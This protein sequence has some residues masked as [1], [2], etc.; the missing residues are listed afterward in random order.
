MFHICFRVYPWLLSYPNSLK[1]QVSNVFMQ[2]L[3]LINMNTTPDNH[4]SFDE[5]YRNR[6]SKILSILFS[7]TTAPF[8]VALF[9]GI[10]WYERYGTD[11]K[12]TLINKL[13]ASQCW[14]FIQYFSV[15]QIIETITFIVGGSPSFVC[16]GQVMMKNS[17]KTQFLLFFDSSIFV[18]YLFIFF[19][20]KSS[21]CQWW[22]LEPFCLH[23]DCRVFT[24]FQLCQ[25]LYSTHPANRLLHM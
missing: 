5:L 8:I 1:S 19:G 6:M 23:V 14:A 22:L 18:Q 12:R 11:N 16:F 24:Y 25:I 15:L 2:S 3:Y 17:Y 21:S 20:Q 7:F 4:N 10:V 9:Y 13:V